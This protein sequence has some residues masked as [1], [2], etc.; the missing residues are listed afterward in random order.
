MKY[1]RYLMFLVLLSL[2][3]FLPI[4]LV[5]AAETLDRS[6]DGSGSPLTA[7]IGIGNWQTF[8]PSQNRLS[9]V[10]VD[11]FRNDNNANVVVGVSMK[12]SHDIGRSSVVVDA[13]SKKIAPGGATLVYDFTDI[14]VTPGDPYRITLTTTGN[15]AWRE[16]PGTCYRGGDAYRDSKIEDPKLD[17]GFAT[18]GYTA[19]DNPPVSALDLDEDADVP[20]V[21][22]DSE[23]NQSNG[24]PVANDATTPSTS[25]VAT[26][27]V[28]PS[29]TGAA[30][31]IIEKTKSLVNQIPFVSDEGGNNNPYIWIVFG[32]AG[33]AVL[34]AVGLYIYLRI[35]KR[36]QDNSSMQ[37]L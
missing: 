31:G 19:E 21:A 36:K 5:R 30:T 37:N 33:L 12:V 32:G 8:L 26:D 4:N 29:Q 14:E 23:Q 27:T 6:C 35:K 20:A 18:Y 9:K 22:D 24:T 2:M 28:S 34:I 7:Q 13:G 16:Q 25:Q 1:I 15:V 10:S 17:Y 11:V 3:V